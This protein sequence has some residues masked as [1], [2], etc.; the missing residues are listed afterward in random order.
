M[1]VTELAR[2][3][4]VNPQELRDYLPQYGFDIGQKAIKIDGHV[5]NK[6]MKEWPD[7]RR[8]IARQK[9]LELQKDKINIPEN[10]TSAE[11]K[12]ISIPR[13]VTVRELAAL[14]GAPLNK[15]LAELMK[16]G[17]FASLNEKIDFDTAWLVGT[18]LGLEIKPAETKKEAENREE[19]EE[20]K[21]KSA[22]AKEEEKDLLPRPPV[23]V[24]MGHVDHGKT[25][26]L[27]AIRRTHVVDGEAGGIT[28]HIGAYQVMRRQKLITFIDTP[29]HEAFTAMRSRGARIADIAILVVAAD[30][31]VKPQTIEA[32]RIIEKAKIPFVVAINKIDKPGANLDKTKQEL[33]SQLN[34]VPEDWGGKT[35][36]APVSAKEGQGIT[37]LLDMV[38]LAAEMEAK[39]LKAN[40][41]A[42]ALGT[43][44]ESHVDKGAGPVATILIQNGTL[45]V[46]D[47]LVFDGIDI[48]RVRGLNNY[49]GEKIESA[50]PATPIQI[51][52]LKALPRVGDIIGVGFGEKMKSKKTKTIVRSAGSQ[53][54]ENTIREDDKAKKINIIIKSDVLGSGEA[55]EESL[56][57][58]NTDKVKVRV[59]SR[60]LGNITEGD[61]KRAEAANGLVI[62]FNVKIPTVIENMAREKN[63]EIKLYNIIYNLINDVKAMMLSALGPVTERKD[64]G[65]LKVKAVFKNEKTS[66]IVG[67]RMEEGRVEKGSMIEVW[68]NKEFL[69]SGVLK[70]LQ[71]A[72]EDVT[73]CETGQEC[74]IEYEGS[75]IIEVGDVLRF[76][77]TEE[78]AGKL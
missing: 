78:T 9:E 25:K 40:P 47:H 64:L 39:S 35:I 58:I 43:I 74:G 36:C 4:R 38:L 51:L 71:S 67:G 75:P 28:Q 11:K 3:L 1:N 70:K 7:I 24:V 73:D 53:M 42:S 66:Q 22:F 54:P 77:K 50:L 46:G 23:I 59:I 44:I 16:N 31:G 13:L 8:K 33:S 10:E 45:K 21:I 19:E 52:G 20:D 65:R 60:G 37:E 18:E 49:Q 32:F 27:D 55:I 12:T 30:D 69:T 2:I 57:K 34:I 61:L 62:G 6:I 48:G 72:K 41:A 17:I 14:S 29:G 56:E 15:I 63:I 5:A 68:R 76:Y 26:L